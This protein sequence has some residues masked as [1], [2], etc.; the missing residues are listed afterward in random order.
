MYCCV[1]DGGSAHYINVVA[2]VSVMG[3]TPQYIIMSM[4]HGSEG[5]TA[6][7]DKLVFKT[8]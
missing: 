8:S 3:G 5:E 6:F 1:G 2:S 7:C 4:S